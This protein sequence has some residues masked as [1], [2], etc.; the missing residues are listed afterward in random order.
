MS[1]SQ[2]GWITFEKRVNVYLDLLAL[3]TLLLK[4]FGW[5]STTTWMDIYIYKLQTRRSIRR[6]GG[7][8]ATTS[9][10]ASA[11]SFR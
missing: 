10:S 9:G 6:R 2:H 3:G 11:F 4:V 7:M 8:C 5:M 1:M